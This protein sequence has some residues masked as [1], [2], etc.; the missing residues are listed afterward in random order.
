MTARRRRLHAALRRA[1]IEIVRYDGRLF[2]HLRRGELLRRL[3]IELVV[4]VGAHNGDWA[5]ALRGSGYRGRIASFEPLSS[6]FATL[7]VTANEDP[8]WECYRLALSVRDGDAVFHVAG[9]S[10]SSSLLPIGARHVRSASESAEVGTKIVQTA[11]LDTI[12]ADLIR[13]EQVY[14]KLDVQGA[15]LDV[16]R[17]ARESLGLID[18]VEAELS[19]VELYEG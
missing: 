15:E 9:N 14:L 11:R 8:F 12:Q 5:C 17:G 13:G 2:P 1:G 6:A 18:A 7:E 10:V 3:G 4:D 16:L 19:L